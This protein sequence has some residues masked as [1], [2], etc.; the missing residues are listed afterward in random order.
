[1]SLSALNERS[2][3][4]WAATEANALGYG[5]VSL[6]VEATGI[7]AVTIRAGQ[8]ELADPDSSASPG[9]IRRPGGG[10]KKV[11]DLHPEIKSEVDKIIK[12]SGNPMKHI[13]W[14][15]LSIDKI[16]AELRR[17]GYAITKTPVN[18][19]LRQE[20]FSLRKNQKELHKKSHPDRDAQFRYI[21]ELAD[22]YLKLGDMVTS[23]DAK[24]TEKIGNFKNDG[25]TYSKPGEATLVE[26]HDFGNKDDNGSIIKAIPFGVYDIKLDKG[27]INVGTDHNTSELAA[28]SIRRWYN[29]EGRIT[30]PKAKNLMITA[31]S[32]GANGNR[33][34]Q[35]KWELQLL[36][37]ETGLNIHV[38]HYPSGTSKWNKIE[39]KMFSYISQNWQGE[40]LRSYEI[41][42]GFIEGT[43]TKTGLSVTAELDTGTYALHKRPTDEQ[44]A[45][46]NLHPHEFHPEWN[47]SI[48][49]QLG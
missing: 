11:V 19:L 7:T 30:Y 20:K 6:V 39:H 12:K 29:K 9:A 35:W 8:A 3:R 36:A 5:G 24:K 42:I 14:T 45:S 48:H 40:P 21:D 43:R 33:V 22:N 23:I 17:R 44:M 32:G 26:D 28:E 41:V 34:K 46:I 1:L 37:N 49:P 15:H 27:Y 10:R 38:C 47:Y 2:R 18:R 16:T 4:L 13:T 31:D 25:T